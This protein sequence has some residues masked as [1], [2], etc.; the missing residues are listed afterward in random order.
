MK[1]TAAP[2]AVRWVGVSRSRFVSAR[3][4]SHGRGPCTRHGTA[5]L[6]GGSAPSPCPRSGALPGTPDERREPGERRHP[7]TRPS[8]L[9]RRAPRVPGAGEPCPPQGEAWGAHRGLGVRP[10]PAAPALAPAPEHMTSSGSTAHEP[11]SRSLTCASARH[12]PVS[13]AEPTGCPCHRRARGNRSE[14]LSFF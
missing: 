10:P 3:G 9:G 12:H 7:A 1:G 14:R 8:A 11:K 2:S 6:A 13:P 5:P 4:L